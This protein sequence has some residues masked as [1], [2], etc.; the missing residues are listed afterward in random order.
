VQKVRSSQELRDEEKGLV[1]KQEFC[2]VR[3]QN[4]FLDY[5]VNP[6]LM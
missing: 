3:G 1:A 5:G 6:I 4:L 2:V